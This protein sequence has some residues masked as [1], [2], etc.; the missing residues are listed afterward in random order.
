MGEIALDSLQGTS[1]R[2]KKTNIAS[3][4]VV[5]VGGREQVQYVSLNN[6]S[7]TKFRFDKI[8]DESKAASIVLLVTS[9]LAISVVMWEK[10]KVK[11]I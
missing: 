10:S 7:G 2:S 3:Q 11:R 9:I 6:H 8:L 1:K 5:L 4:L